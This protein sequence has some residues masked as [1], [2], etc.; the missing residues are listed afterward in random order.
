[1]DIPA[2]ASLDPAVVL[3]GIAL[4]VLVLVLVGVIVLLLRRPADAGPA[5]LELARLQ[6]AQNG[7]QRILREDLVAQA[8]ADRREVADTLGDMSRNL[9]SQMTSVASLQ[10]RQIDAFAGQLEKLTGANEARLAALRDTLE[11]S[12][13]ELQR[14]NASRLDAVRATVDEKLQATLEQR[15]GESFRLVSAQLEQVHKG[16]GEMQA[17][18]ADVGDLKRVLGNVRTRGSWGEV[19]LGALLEQMLLPEQYATNVEVVGGSRERVEFAVRLPGHLPETPVWLPVDA[20]FPREDY[21]RLM[22]AYEQADAAAAESAARALE[23][24]VRAEGRRIAEKYIAP[25]ETTDFAVLYL[26]TEGL[27]AEAARR[28]GLLDVLQR[29]HRVVLAGPTTIA[30]MLTSLQ[31][32]FR[33]LAV[34]RRSSEVWRL[35][36]AVKTEFA[37]FGDILAK[38]REQIERAAS[39]IGSAETR[40]RVIARRLRDVES[41][42]EREA[43]RAL[44]G[45]VAGGPDDGATP[46]D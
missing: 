17:L 33:T 32:G 20:K 34:E 6:A 29:E 30:A 25:P 44:R 22:L 4:V 13:R 11:N 26:A 19:Q 7:H 15:L 2:I 46:S 43:G 37:R 21:D 18:A 24:R 28:P 9:S 38:T 36:G 12:I 35:L 1:M 40:T 8:R 41:L 23:A 3:V 10:N 16:L 39:T 42:P 14:D 31:M 5:L 45:D 27:Y